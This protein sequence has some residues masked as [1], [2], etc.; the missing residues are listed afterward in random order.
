MMTMTTQ[1]THLIL[2]IREKMKK[3]GGTHVALDVE[4]ELDV[5]AFIPMSMRNELRRQAVDAYK[6][7]VCRQ[8]RYED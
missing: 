8:Y 6:E 3:T 7:A 1:T 2:T 5:Q 4:C